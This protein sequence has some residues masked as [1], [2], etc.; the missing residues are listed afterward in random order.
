MYQCICVYCLD[1]ETNSSMY[2]YLLFSP[3][4]HLV[5]AAHQSHLVW[6]FCVLTSSLFGYEHF[7]EAG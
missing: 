1:T 3:S 7:F 5:Q 4:Q 2:I 6:D